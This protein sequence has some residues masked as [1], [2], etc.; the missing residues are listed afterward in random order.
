[1]KRRFFASYDNGFTLVEV[2]V[3]MAVFSIVLL[4][5]MTL[6]VTATRTNA[7][8][9]KV[10]NAALLAETI[11]DQIENTSYD[12]IT[13]NTFP[14]QDYGTIP[15]FP[16]FRTE[17]VITDNSPIPNLKTIVMRLYWKDTGGTKTSSGLLERNLEVR[18]LIGKK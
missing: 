8:A 10:G 4:G 18:T 13:I 1:M 5:F 17:V 3:A 16:F 2:M 11:L 9:Q 7:T 15:G 12:Q 14:S 6:Q